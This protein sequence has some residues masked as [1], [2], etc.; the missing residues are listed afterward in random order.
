MSHESR[1]EQ[2]AERN[3]V[4]RDS[5]PSVQALAPA[6]SSRLAASVEKSTTG[7]TS[8]LPSRAEGIRECDKAAFG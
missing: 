6:A 8:M 4:T 5:G 3:L 7:R 1:A 2:E